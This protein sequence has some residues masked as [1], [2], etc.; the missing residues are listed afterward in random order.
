MKKTSKI[1]FQSLLKVEIERAVG[2]GATRNDAMCSVSRYVF[3]N[4]NVLL[5]NIHIFS[6][7]NRTIRG[8]KITLAIRRQVTQQ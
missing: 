6:R 3:L 1:L 8:G 4:K 5:D 2:E 7:C